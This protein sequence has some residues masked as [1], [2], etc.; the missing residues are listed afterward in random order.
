MK[1]YP[2]LRAFASYIATFKKSFLATALAFSI[3]NI[4]LAVLPLLIG[5]LTESLTTNS[6][7]A[8]WWLGAVI[9]ASILHNILWIVA[10]FLYRDKL[11]ERLHRFDDIV[12]GNIMT[13]DYGFFTERFTGKISSYAGTLGQELRDICDNFMHSYSAAIVFMPVFVATMFSVNIYIGALFTASL[14]A[15]FVGGKPLAKRDAAAERK[16]ADAKSTIDGYTVD[17]IANFMAIKSFGNEQTEAKHLY[18]KRVHL[19]VVSKYAY[20]RAI[21]FWGYM[22]TVVRMFMWTATFAMVIYQYLHGDI[23]IAQVSTFV[24]AIM[25]YQSYIWEIVWNFSQLNIKIARIEEAYRYLFGTRDIIR[26]PLPATSPRLPDSAFKNSLEIRNMHFAYPD[27]P[28]VP[29]LQN[30]SMT[31]QVGEKIGIVG[32]SGGGKSTL[33]KLLLGYYPV[34]PDTLLVDGKPVESSQLTDLLSYVPQ[35][36]SVFH[37]SVRDNIAYARPDATTEQVI[38]AAKHAQAHQ[39]IS[40]LSEGYDTL[41]GERGVKLS[42]GQ[43]Q[44]IAI[45]RALLKNAPLLLLDEATSALDSES[46]LLIQRAFSDLLAGRTAIVIAHR[47]ST[48]QRMDRIL[49][50]V[51]GRIVQQGSHAQ[52]VDQPG[53][54][55]ALWQH[56][57]GGF[58]ED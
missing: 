17:S 7:Q 6:G 34:E 45:A 32:P 40:T 55:R 38:A 54:Y 16:Q 56:Q 44:R 50:I 58:L 33:L 12:F 48:I 18:A 37:R 4:P 5:Q 24:A 49:V 22:G 42:G 57:S 46:E 10:D 2:S 36:T 39:F 8:I 31:V 41:V 14:V 1:N 43:R 11:L 47:L 20:L 53:M 28:D 3:A 26:Q 30:I 27:K 9:G 19:I 15:M 21:Y 35:D 23:S 52:L 51:K 25:V 13:H 29:V